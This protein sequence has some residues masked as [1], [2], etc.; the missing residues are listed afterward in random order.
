MP[1]I[2]I[3]AAGHR[4]YLSPH[5]AYCIQRKG[6]MFPSTCCKEYLSPL[7]GIL[8]IKNSPPGSD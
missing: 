4:K 5:M 2:V 6:P 1:S 8:N 3:S 7:H